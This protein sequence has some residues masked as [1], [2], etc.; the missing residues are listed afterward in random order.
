MGGKESD[1]C[2]LMVLKLDKNLLQSFSFCDILWMLIVYFKRKCVSMLV[3][4]VKM[5]S[6]FLY[7]D[8]LKFV[9]LSC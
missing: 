6:H 9:V 4:K 3:F 5:D 8:T 2:S 1:F 7:H